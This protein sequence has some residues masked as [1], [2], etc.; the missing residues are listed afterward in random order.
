MRTRRNNGVGE[1]GGV[2]RAAGYVEGP[3]D[4]SLA[5]LVG[6]LLR[7]CAG[8]AAARFYRLWDITARRTLLMRVE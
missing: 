2:E 6:A 7:I 3:I 8:T 4:Q 1:T 5:H